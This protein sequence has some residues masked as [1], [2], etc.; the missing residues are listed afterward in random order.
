MTHI[1]QGEPAPG[2]PLRTARRVAEIA[3]FRVVEVLERAKALE[4]Q[5][6]D[7][8]H[9]EVGEPDF[10]T[11]PAIVAAGQ[12]ALAGG[13]TRYTESLGIPEL[14]A[15]IAD[16]YQQMGVSIAADRIVVTNG[17]SGALTLAAALLLDPDSEL[18]LPDPGY[19]C[20]TVFARLVGA[21]PVALAT[22]AENG[23]APTPAQVRKAWTGQTRALLIASPSNPTGAVLAPAAL[24][25]L[26]ETVQS[27][28]GV[29]LLDEIYQGLVFGDN[30]ARWSGLALGDDMI[31][32]NSFSKYFC[33]TGWRLGWLVLP[34]GA[35]NAAAAL[36]QNLFISPSAPAQ[37]A[38]LAAF[39]P[40]VLALCDE[41]RLAYRE[42]RDALITGLR[43]LGF[44]VPVVP[45]GAF[46]LFADLAP[47]QLPQNGLQFARQLLEE[48][49]VAVTPGIDFGSNQ[50]ERYVRFAYTDTV[51]R[52][53]Q[54]L[55]RIADAIA[56]WRQR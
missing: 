25:A 45:D 16:Y 40:E 18:L 27:L 9:L 35:S 36:V 6:H 10:E 26:Y 39:A 48:A 32:I 37:Q 51:P 1:V 19:P 17:A 8:I 15:A 24:R 55:A 13:H 49:H 31:V 5:G 14:R 3:P 12:R 54:A 46:Y 7:V 11:P 21:R 23:F 29:L 44:G 28:G 41:R 4:R 33:M 56:R 42:R 22:S 52:I 47:L 30:A 43:Q 20:N 50:T 34:P 53:N 2:T 38:A